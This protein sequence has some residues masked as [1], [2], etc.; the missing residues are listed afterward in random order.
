MTSPVALGW[1]PT[2]QLGAQPGLL[3]QVLIATITLYVG[4]TLLI[5]LHGTRNMTAMSAADLG[6][7]LAVGAVIGRTALL[8]VPTLAT[9]L[10]AVVTLL[11]LQRLLRRAQ[12][13]RPLA[14]VI[15]P[16]P[17]LLMVDGRMDAQAMRR[18]GIGRDELLQQ[19]RLAG[20]SRLDQARYVVLERNGA[21]SVLRADSEID[22]ALL[23]DIP[24]ATFR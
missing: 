15:T 9:G 3:V 12:R 16:T 14:R 1:L 2:D 5:R 22:P 19:L 23:A 10:A 20:V 13:W 6:C 24:A 4:F 18:A 11:V 17:V 8:A 21:L 7:V